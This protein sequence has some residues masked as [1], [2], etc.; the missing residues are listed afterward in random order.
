MTFF[1][2][3]NST[4]ILYPYQNLLNNHI[5]LYSLPTTINLV[6]PFTI[7]MVKELLILLQIFKTFIFYGWLLQK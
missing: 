1:T 5:K 4:K 2:F 7:K 6:H 3:Q